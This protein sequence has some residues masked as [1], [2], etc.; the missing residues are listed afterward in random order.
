[1]QRERNPGAAGVQIEKV[2]KYPVTRGQLI[3]GL[4]LIGTLGVLALIAGLSAE[5]LSDRMVAIGL[6]LC[7]LWLPLYSLLAIF[8]VINVTTSSRGLTIKNALTTRSVNWEEVTEFGT[9]RRIGYQ[10]YF[11]VFYLKA[12]RYGDRKIHVCGP[13]IENINALLDEVFRKAVNAR[14]VRIENEALIPFTRKMKIVPWI[15]DREASNR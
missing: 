7:F 12:N 14:F 3:I 10:Q 6:G 8:G 4:P 2:Y 1:M 5:V 13:S 15:R 9:Y 11:T